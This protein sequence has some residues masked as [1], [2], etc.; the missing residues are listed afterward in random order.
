[1]A[2]NYFEEE[3]VKAKLKQR[4]QLSQFITKEIVQ[5]HLDMDKI[6]INYVFCTDESLL[7]KNIQFLDHNTLTDI[8]TFDLSEKE[9]ELLA[10]LYISIDRVTENAKLFETPYQ[11][12]LHRVLFHGVLH[13][14]GFKDKTK[15]EAA[16]MR[17][18]EEQCL[19]AYF[20]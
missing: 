10:E 12:E 19:N 1:M 3:G 20:N 13:L 7:E 18:Q 15:D 6:Q 14:C 9:N 4:R 16:T 2:I 17:E 11:R 8:I 5:K